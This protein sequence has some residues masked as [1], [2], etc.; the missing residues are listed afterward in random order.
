MPATFFARAVALSAALASTV[1]GLRSVEAACNAY[2]CGANTPILWGTFV[3]GL[4]TTGEA[5]AERVVLRPELIPS[6][7]GTCVGDDIKLTSVD[8]R[9]T[10]VRDKVEVCADAA[11]VGSAFDLDVPY[12]ALTMRVRVRIDEIKTVSTWEVEGATLLPTYRFKVIASGAIAAPGEAPPDGARPFGPVS[13]TPLCQ[14]TPGWMEEWQQEGLVPRMVNPTVGYIT[15]EN[16]DGVGGAQWQV[17]TDHALI[18][19]GETYTETGSSA[20]VGP[21]WFQIACAGSAIAEMRLLGVDPWEQRAIARGL[22][23]ATLKMMGARYTG[24]QAF[25]RPGTPVRWQRWDA[26][27]FY[28]GP[29]RDLAPGPSEAMWTRDGATCVDHL[30]LMRASFGVRWLDWLEAIVRIRLARDFRRGGCPGGDR[31]VWTTTTVDHI[32]H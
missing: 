23:V 19:S 16:P 30:R 18:V 32:A 6:G 10:G 2:R 8:G 4:S 13:P 5:N 11:L 25:T 14:E 17:G 9:L 1:L 12:K 24:D 26:R 20:K 28:G 22:T 15:W 27:R 29:A 31:A 7:V 21:Q 3:R